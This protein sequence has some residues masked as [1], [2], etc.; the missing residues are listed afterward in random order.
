LFLELCCLLP[1]I[2]CE[3]SSFYPIDFLGHSS[4]PLVDRWTSLPLTRGSVNAR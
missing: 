4:L 3:N 1:V 2:P